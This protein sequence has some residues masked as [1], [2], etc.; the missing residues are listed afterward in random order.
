[1]RLRATVTEYES[2]RRFRWVGR[3]PVPGLLR[4][5]HTHEVE[6]LPDG[7]TRHVLRQRFQG[8]LVPPMGRLVSEADVSLMEANANLKARVEHGRAR[9]AHQE[10]TAA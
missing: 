10:L 7:R 1:V 5:E 3:L 9:L 6:P 8:A 4:V 2:G